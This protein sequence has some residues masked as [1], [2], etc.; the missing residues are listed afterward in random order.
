MPNSIFS[1]E[2]V[3]EVKG[4]LVQHCLHFPLARIFLYALV[5][6]PWRDEVV[7]GAE[8]PESPSGWWVCEGSEATCSRPWRERDTQE[9]TPGSLWVLIGACQG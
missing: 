7:P 3:Q 5:G 4:K 1:V 6:V 2:N 8:N 9:E